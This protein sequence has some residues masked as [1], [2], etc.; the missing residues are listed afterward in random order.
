[1]RDINFYFSGK[2]FFVLTV[3][4]IVILTG[5]SVFAQTADSTLVDTLHNQLIYP[6]RDV[7]GN[8]YLDTLN[9]SPLF[10]KD[11][12]NIKQE[13]IYNPKTNSYEFV[14]KV[15][16]FEY[17][18]PTTLDFEDYQNLQMKRSIEKYWQQSTQTTGT[19][20][21]KRLI[22]KL[23][24]KGK[25]FEQIFGSNAIDIRPQGSAEISFGVLSNFR[26]DP[27]LDVRQR[28]TTNFDFNEKIQM[29]V[30]AK[31]GTKLTFKAAYN[32]ESSFNFENQLKLRYTGTK[33]DIIQSIEAGNVSLPLNSTLITGA[34]SLFGVKTKLQFGK[35]SVT[36]VFSQQQSETKNI[37][38]QNGA[39]QNS[40]KLTPLDYE[41][42]RHF[43]ISQFFRDHYEKA[44]STLPIISSD[45]NITKIEVWVTNIGP[46][47]EENRNIIAFT[48]LA[49]GK[50]KEIFNKYVHALP[51]GVIPTNN[52]NDLIQRMDTAQLRNINSVSTYLTGDP[53]GIGR[54]NYFV[55]GQD[56]V[57]LETARRLKPS[58]YTVNKKLGFI[59]LNTTLNQDQVLAVA[60]QYTVI[61]HD[62]V[63]Q[64]G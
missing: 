21:G 5:H 16:D 15:G 4:A 57:K 24:I 44:L 22:P 58:E 40:F 53:L 49:E 33:D 56:F 55:S 1:M 10:L 6:F 23:Y 52:S 64:I 50:Q 34:Q 25:A 30:T 8:P 26:D 63:F 38:V 11:P 60:V 13:I 9:Q 59:S 7:T 41:D 43:F 35:T 61:G 31:I 17:R 14:T 2:L 36:A 42:N 32:T 62:S 20:K 12:N 27:S 29:N 54:N 51:N 45:V 47:T 28:H 37:T 39:Q 3:T 48:D 46:A 18:T 19:N